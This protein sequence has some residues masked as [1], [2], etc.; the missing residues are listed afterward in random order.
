MV[1][2]KDRIKGGEFYHNFYFPNDIIKN[3]FDLKLVEERKMKWLAFIKLEKEK[4]HKDRTFGGVFPDI[5]DKILKVETILENYDRVV[6]HLKEERE[7]QDKGKAQI[8]KE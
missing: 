5:G 7:V 2:L 6:G 8:I 4:E 1:T 3:V